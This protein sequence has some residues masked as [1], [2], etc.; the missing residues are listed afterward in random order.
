M[1][2]SFRG[3][4]SII[5]GLRVCAYVCVCVYVLEYM[6]RCIFCNETN[7]GDNRQILTF[8]F[9]TASSISDTTPTY[10]TI[11]SSQFT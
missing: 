6:Y 9:S 3:L 7:N 4:V 11:R 10:G 2:L 5:V 1:Y 8:V